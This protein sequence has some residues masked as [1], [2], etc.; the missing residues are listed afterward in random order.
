MLV[1]GAGTARGA[2]CAKA[3]NCDISF[4]VHRGGR[5]SGGRLG[6]DTVGRSSHQRRASV[7]RRSV[8]SIAGG[9][10]R[11]P[12]RRKNAQDNETTHRQL[13]RCHR[14]RAR[15]RSGFYL[16]HEGPLVR[17]AQP[18]RAPILIKVVPSLFGLARAAARINSIRRPN[19]A[20]GSPCTAS[21][22][23][24]TSS[25]NRHAVS[26]SHLDDEL[27]R[28]DEL[29]PQ[30]KCERSVKIHSPHEG[31]SIQSQ[32]LCHFGSAVAPRHAGRADV[33]RQAIESASHFVAIISATVCH[34]S[35]TAPTS[36]A[37][38]A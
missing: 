27:V 29:W 4:S 35:V 33:M 18:P 16:D 34:H 19:A 2:L 36:E 12:L 9:K 8:P 1:S 32:S 15:R 23:Q 6:A 37:P 31:A 38:A 20:P 7:A 22:T 10:R 30:E 14:D 13:A 11:V 25:R 3:G 5:R 26:A 21:I 28:S 17:S 24:A